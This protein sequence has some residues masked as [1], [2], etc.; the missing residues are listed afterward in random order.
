MP[1]ASVDDRLAHVVHELEELRDEVD[2]DGE[3]AVGDK[4]DEGLHSLTAAAQAAHQYMSGILL[5]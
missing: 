4:I 2:Y 5:I 3:Y 1:H